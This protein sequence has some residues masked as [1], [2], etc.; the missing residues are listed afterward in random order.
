MA[1]VQLATGRFIEERRISVSSPATGVEWPLPRVAPESVGLCP[2]RLRRV[3]ALVEEAVQRGTVAGVVTLVARQGGIAHLACHGWAD[4][5]RRRPMSEDAIFRIYSMSKI[6]TTVG[7]LMLM[8][9]GRFL[10]KE[11]VARFLDAPRL[12]SD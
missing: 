2:R 8:E 10:L 1:A 6:V 12:R 3:D 7:A 9:E 4:I 5:E 11:P